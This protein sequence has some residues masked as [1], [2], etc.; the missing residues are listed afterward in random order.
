MF[1]GWPNGQVWP[2]LVASGLSFGLG[3]TLQ[4]RRMVKHLGHIHKKLDKI[5]GDG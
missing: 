3:M 5:S 1:L 2:N 4:H